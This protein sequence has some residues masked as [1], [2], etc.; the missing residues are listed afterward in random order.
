MRRRVALD[1]QSVALD[2]LTHAVRPDLADIRLADRVFAP[3][4]AAP[5]DRMIGMETALRVD[6]K[7]GARVLATLAPGSAF[8]LLDI[9]GGDAWGIAVAQSLVGYVHTAALLEP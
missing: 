8:E 7:A 1:G 3:H 9:V 2:P 6:R 5:V 4:Y